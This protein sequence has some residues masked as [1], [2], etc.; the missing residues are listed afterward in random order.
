MPGLTPNRSIRYPLPGESGLGAIQ[1]EQAVA[2]LDV[3]YTTT[4]GL[5]SQAVHKPYAALSLATG[6]PSIAK[7]TVTTLGFTRT[8]YDNQLADLASN[9]LKCQVAG[10]YFLRGYT[11]WLDTATLTT[12]CAVQLALSINGSTSLPT[13]IPHKLTT[14]LGQENFAIDTWGLVPLAVNDV[15]TLT[16][17]WT[18]ANTPTV[19]VQNTILSGFMWCTNP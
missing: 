10:L 19:T 16:F 4:D 8:T 17:F 14:V 2:D 11:T 13:F 9:R 5:R 7:N 18:A 12:P 1:L 15:V 6:A 3:A